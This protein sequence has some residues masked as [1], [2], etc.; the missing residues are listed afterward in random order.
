[1]ARV[2][3]GAQLVEHDHVPEVDVGGR[4]VDPQLDPQRPPTLELLG[5]TALGQRLD[6]ALEQAPR[7]RGGRGIRHRANARLTRRR[8]GTCV[9]RAFLG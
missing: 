6:G 1:M 8:G 5:Q 4:R 2:L 9:L 7:L 3:E